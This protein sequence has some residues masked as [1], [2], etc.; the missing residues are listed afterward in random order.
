MPRLPLERILLLLQ[1]SPLLDRL[2]QSS[3]K[4]DDLRFRIILER[5]RPGE[6]GAL[7][8]RGL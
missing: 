1:L 7:A 3:L 2:A 8:F 4:L 6:G 5:F